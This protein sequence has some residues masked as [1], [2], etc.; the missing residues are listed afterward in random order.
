MANEIEK[1]KEAFLIYQ[2]NRTHKNFLIVRQKSNCSARRQM[3]HYRH[4]HSCRPSCE[5]NL[6]IL[7]LYA[8][9]RFGNV[10]P[11]ELNAG[12]KIMFVLS[13]RP[14][15][16][17]HRN[18]YLCRTLVLFYSLKT[19]QNMY[20]SFRPNPPVFCPQTKRSPEKSGLLYYSICCAVA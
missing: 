13:F 15:I 14:I 1:R 18:K 3:S 6:T 16:M 5:I 12:K 7:I 4:D 20:L 2:D 19:R 9:P 11:E 10:I 8:F 17:N